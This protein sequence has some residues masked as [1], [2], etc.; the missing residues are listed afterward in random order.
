[1]FLHLDYPKQH[2]SGKKKKKYFSE[3]ITEPPSG[4]SL[5]SDDIKALA[6]QVKD[7]V[8]RLSLWWSR[9]DPQPGSVGKDPM[10]LQLWYRFS[11]WPGDL[12]YALGEAKKKK[13]KKEK[14][15]KKKKALEK[16]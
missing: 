13:K 14:K 2:F 5:T 12:P 9:L 10:F 7:P 11:P 4:V 6:K 16:P 1:M 15:K 8:S 3:K